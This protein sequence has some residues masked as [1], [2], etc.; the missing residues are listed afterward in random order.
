MLRL[1]LILAFGAGIAVGLKAE[2]FLQ[3]GRCEH[4][5]GVYDSAGYCLNLVQ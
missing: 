4:A 5:G 3:E 1:M 2:R